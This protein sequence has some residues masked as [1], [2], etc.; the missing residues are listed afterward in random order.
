MSPE[1]CYIYFI[2]TVGL[3]CSDNINYKL[4]QQCKQHFKIN[5]SASEHFKI[6]LAACEHLKINQLANTSQYIYWPLN[7]SK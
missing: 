2:Q 7:T 3:H 1:N 6:N 5:L 4:K